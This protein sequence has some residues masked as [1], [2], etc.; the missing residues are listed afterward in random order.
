MNFVFAPGATPSVLVLGSAAVFPVHRIYCVGR[1]Y[2]EHAREMGATVD[3]S[4]P[5]FFMKPADAIV[6]GNADV[7]YPSGTA[8]LHH[9][10]EMVV[11]L[12]SGGRDIPV[13]EALQHVYG[14]AV[15]LDLTRRDLQAAAKAKGMPW[16][17]AKGFDHSAPIS[18]L[19]PIGDA[20]H[21]VQG[22]LSLEV[23]GTTRQK[24]NIADMVFSVA[25]IIHELSRLYIL[26]AGD[27]IYTGTP[28]G[29]AALQRG[30]HFRARLDGV[31]QFEG[32][33]V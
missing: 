20:A 19:R 26:A 3:R 5:T 23:N 18:A 16:D 10:V 31:A 12:Q 8:D 11:A 6:T 25:E 15:G 9:E 21:P 24:A 28:A 4:Q 13:S 27:L 14:Y 17:T 2:A 30:D 1:N 7:P 32:R 33:I 29:V 22:E